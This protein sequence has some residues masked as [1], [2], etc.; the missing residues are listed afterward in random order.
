M[1][2]KEGISHA[3]KGVTYLQFQ[4]LTGKSRSRKEIDQTVGQ[5]NRKLFTGLRRCCAQ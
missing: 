2:I 3:S 1:I 4:C 5:E